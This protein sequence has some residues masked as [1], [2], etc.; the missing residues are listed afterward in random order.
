MIANGPVRAAAPGN[1]S[2]GC[3]TPTAVTA[4]P[5]PNEGVSQALS[6]LPTLNGTPRAGAAASNACIT[7]T[8]TPPPS[9]SPTPAPTVKVP[10]T[11]TP[12]ATSAA[13]KGELSAE[14][15][16]PDLPGANQ[17]GYS[18]DLKAKL[19]VGFDTVPKQ[20]PIYE[21]ARETFS[22]QQVQTLADQLQIG[23]KVTDRGSGSF[24]VTGK[25][26]LFVSP[27]LVQYISPVKAASG[28]LPA[29]DDAVAMAREWLR[30]TGMTPP[31]IGTGSVA[32]QNADTSRMVI[33][34]GP[35]EPANVLAAYPS[36]TVTLDPK[37][38]VLQAT[39]RWDTIQRGDLY[40][41]RPAK[42]VWQLV[43]S[44]QAYI[45]ADLPADDYPGGT[46][47]K[48]SAEYSN[49]SIAYTTAGP[50]GGNQFLEPVFVFSGRVKPDKSKTTYAIRAY[51]PALTLSNQPVG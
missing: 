4:T 49:I 22:A 51:V 19:T 14:L 31:D 13:A 17:Q 8:A 48:G 41:L 42:D 39:S 16:P 7:P 45:E 40:Q 1:A 21:L 30:E 3:A 6:Q 11:P 12:N 47:I 25:G 2:P 20:A 23:G 50:P 38:Q 43:Q 37:G 24:V 32:S 34:F 18:F 28:K 36:V 5:S 35:I 44:G 10:P 33:V 9:P 29:P 26:Q 46:T 15:P 27:D